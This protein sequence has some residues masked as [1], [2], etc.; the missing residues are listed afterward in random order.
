MI[1][2]GSNTT[3]APMYV[4]LTVSISALLHVSMLCGCLH[5]SSID[6][7]GVDGTRNEQVADSLRRIRY[8]KPRVVDSVARS[9]PFVLYAEIGGPAVSMLSAHAEVTLKRFDTASNILSLFHTARASIGSTIL[10]FTQF[11]IPVIGKMLFFRSSSHLEI[12][13]GATFLFPEIQSATSDLFE[14]LGTKPLYF[15]IIGYRYEPPLGGFVFRL[16]YTPYWTSKPHDYGN[17]DKY[18]IF[19]WGISIGHAF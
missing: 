16:A 12:G 8:S 10:P 15:L 9:S 1:V 17:G 2:P 18:F 3:I 6:S 19:W 14:D 11:A 13:A 4:V 5:A 7:A